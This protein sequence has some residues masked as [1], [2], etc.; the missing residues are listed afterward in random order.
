MKSKIYWI[1]QLLKKTKQKMPDW[2]YFYQSIPSILV[3]EWSGSLSS[4]SFSNCQAAKMTMQYIGFFGVCFLGFI[5]VWVCIYFFLIYGFCFCM[6]WGFCCSVFFFLDFIG[7]K[8]ESGITLT[9]VHM[10]FF[11][12]FFLHPPPHP[13]YQ[14]LWAAVFSLIFKVLYTQN[15]Y[16]YLETGLQQMVK[17]NVSRVTVS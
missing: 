15:L 13:N 11:D 1:P 17:N 16:G 6:L 4:K 7:E 3:A 14:F 8:G 5:L 10:C 9:E 12:L 2:T